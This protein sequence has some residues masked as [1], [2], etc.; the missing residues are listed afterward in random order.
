GDNVAVHADPVERRIISIGARAAD[1]DI[2]GG[3]RIGAGSD[4]VLVVIEDGEGDAA[5]LLQGIDKGGD[6]PVAGAFDAPLGA[7]FLDRRDDAPLAGARLGQHAIVDQAN[8]AAAEIGLLEERPDVAAG[9]LLAGAVGDLLDN[10][11]E[12]DLQRA[13]EIEPVIGLDDIGDP[14]LAGLAVDPDHRLIAA[15]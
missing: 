8:P 7:P 12:L 3:L 11:A 13:G 6:R 10:A 4:R 15:P 9:Q 2:G 14:A 1:L 5:T